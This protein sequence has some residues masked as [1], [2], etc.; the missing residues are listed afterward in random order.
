VQET[1]PKVVEEAEPAGKED[2]IQPGTELTIDG[3]RFAIDSI[4]RERLISEFYQHCSVDERLESRVCKDYKNLAIRFLGFSKG[5][6]SRENVRAYLQSYTGKAP[7]T[8]NNQLCG[9]RAFVGRFLKHPEYVEGFKKAH[10]NQNYDIELPTKTQLK[11]G[12]EGLTDNRERAIYLFY[13]T[14]GLRHTEGLKLNRYEDIDY[15]LR[16]VKSKHSTRT[17]K[18]GV[19]IYNE[20]CE[21]YLKKYLASRKDN[22]LRLFCIGFREFVRIWR[23]ASESAGVSIGPQIMRKWHSTE[24]GELGVPDRYVDIFQGRAPQSVIGKHYTGKDLE[25]LKRIYEKAG[26][27]VLS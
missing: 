20:E 22:S 13:G 2:D 12:F 18:A 26:L 17:K 5:M 6:V 7:K 1:I 8:Y 9:L 3:R 14:T 23:K 11:K 19:S 4:N 15:E 16:T 25:R 24:L 21:L 27:K 10:V